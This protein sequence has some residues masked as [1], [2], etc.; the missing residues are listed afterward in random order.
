MRGS[1][2]AFFLI[3][4]LLTPTL[5]SRRGSF[6]LN[7][8]AVTL[9]RGNDVALSDSIS[10][11]ILFILVPCLPAA[12]GALWIASCLRKIHPLLDYDRICSLQ[13]VVGGLGANAKPISA[14][15][16]H[17]RGFRPRTD[18]SG[19]RPAG[20]VFEKNP[21]GCLARCLCLQRLTGLVCLLAT[22]IPRRC[23][24]VLFLPAVF[25]VVNVDSD[26]NAD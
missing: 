1:N 17:A 7:L 18:D 15:T 25:C 24:D 10:T 6:F 2:K 22:S 14:A 26:D 19:C 23:A 5:S 12:S 16:R 21:H 20:R 3:F 11:L 4:I 8:M 13:F 9:R